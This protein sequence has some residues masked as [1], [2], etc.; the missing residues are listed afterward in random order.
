M[1]I[2]V[3]PEAAGC[4]EQVDTVPSPRLGDILVAESKITREEVEAVVATKGEEPIGVALTRA[5]SVSTTDVAGALHTQQKRL[6][7]GEAAVDSSVRVRTDR[8]D[9]LIDMIGELVIA[10]SMVAQD[11]LI[12]DGSHH[13]V[14][15]KL[16][17]WEKLYGNCRT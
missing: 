5:G 7:A 12:A 3:D 4:S 8:L 17:M 9:S 14:Q 6:V 16:P 10:H 1:Q 15:K 2:L 11:E 13:S